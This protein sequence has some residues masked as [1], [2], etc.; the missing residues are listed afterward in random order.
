MLFQ[1]K[2]S[3]SKQ[4]TLIVVIAFQFTNKKTQWEESESHLITC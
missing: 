1:L 4:L 3:A 2:L